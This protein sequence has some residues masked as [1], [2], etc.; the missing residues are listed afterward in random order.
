MSPDPT[1]SKGP[2]TPEARAART[3]APAPLDGCEDLVDY[4]PTKSKVAYGAANAAN[5]SLSGIALGGALTFFYNIKMGLSGDLI[6]LAW[7]LFAAW[8]AI[9]DPLLGILEDRTRSSAG[10]HLPYIRYGAPIYGFLFIL[11]WYP[12]A[13][14]QWGLFF[15]FLLVLF[16]VDTIYSMV[17]L[18]TYALPAEMCITAESRTNL[19]LWS[20]LIGVVGILVSNLVPLVLLTGDKSAALNPVFRPVM[21]LLGVTCAVVMFVAS[22]FLKENDFAQLEQP[23]G[24]VE[25]IKETFKNK[26]FLIFLVQNFALVLGQYTLTTGIFYYIDYVLVLANWWDYIPVVA[27]FVLVVF[28][29]KYFLALVPKYGVKRICQF[30]LTVMGAGLVL[31]FFLGR[32]IW[33]AIIGLVPVVIGLAAVIMTGQAIFGDAIDYDEVRTGKRRE[34]TYSGVNALVTKPAVSIANWAFLALIL[35]FGFQEPVD[36]QIFEQTELAITGILFAL[37]IVPGA[38]LLLAALVLRWFPLDG[39]EWIEQKVA[40]Q[41]EHARKEREY[42]AQLKEEGAL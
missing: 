17:G 23:L 31:L 3:D 13:D 9:N 39:P 41:R 37:T 27:M 2:D 19:L 42:V 34:T 15:N 32:N 7:M 29:V 26:P 10:R 14:S 22:Y 6:G 20:T 5:M 36:G 18:V 11:T 33:T 4:L 24:L 21:I 38:F 12:F 25:G 30:G 1:P 28:G 35:A 16:C 8:N 40:L